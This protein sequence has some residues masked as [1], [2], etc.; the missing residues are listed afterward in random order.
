MKLFSKKPKTP[1]VVPDVKKE[2]ISIKEATSAVKN[3]KLVITKAEVKVGIP[4]LG[5]TFTLKPRV[6]EKSA[7]L[8]ER[9]VYVFDVPKEATKGAIAKAVSTIWKVH[10]TKVAIIRNAG[11][12]KIAR[13]KKG[14]TRDTKK[15]YVYL[16]KGEK[17]EIV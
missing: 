11:K 12:I 3:S 17:I 16:K 13:G 1:T 4:G 2:K 5:V 8:A 7:L 15:A 10:P 9:N 14:R 6:T